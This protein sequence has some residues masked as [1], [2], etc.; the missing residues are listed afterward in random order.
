M[1]KKLSIGVS[2]IARKGKKGW[3]GVDNKA[4]K[5]KKMWVGDSNGKAR[6]CWSGFTPMY[7]F[8][9]ESSGAA[10]YSEDGIQW[11][12]NSI[13]GNSRSCTFGSE[14]YFRVDT[15]NN[16]YYS[17]DG[18]V[19]TLSHTFEQSIRLLRY[20]GDGYVYAFS[21]YSTKNDWIW[22]TNDGVTWEGISISVP[23]ISASDT[24]PLDVR[25][26]TVGGKASYYFVFLNSFGVFQTDSIQNGAIGT[27]IIFEQWSPKHAALY[28]CNDNLFIVIVTG[29]ASGV[30]KYNSAASTGATSIFTY[31][32]S[33]TR[34]SSTD[35]GMVIVGYGKDVYFVD[36]YGGYVKRDVKVTYIPTYNEYYNPLFSCAWDGT[37]RVVIFAREPANTRGLVYMYT[38]DYGQTWTTGTKTLNS[39][40]NYA[41]EACY[42]ID[43]GGHYSG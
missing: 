15:S 30:Y 25:Y 8:F 43:G 32:G 17:E 9:S 13:Q 28:I 31:S 11:N 41:A 26:G 4:R 42:G 33:I 38:D 5:I 19:W 12:A 7:L 29:G 22:K 10:G 6:L 37:K 40:F 16:V 27:K 20:L 35:E 2:N 21:Y 14:K 36:K 18:I 39:G 34:I 23:Y 3:I 1:G 24:Y